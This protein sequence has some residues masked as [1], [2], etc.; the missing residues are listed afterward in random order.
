MQ[1]ESNQTQSADI[2]I[3]ASIR[4]YELPNLTQLLYDF[5]NKEQDVIQQCFRT[6]NYASLRDLPVQMMPNSIAKAMRDKQDMNLAFKPPEGKVVKLS[7]GGLFR[8]YEYISEP[9]DLYLQQKQLENKERKLKQ[10]DIS[11]KEFVA[12][13]DRYV[14][15]YHDCFLSEE[16]KKNYVLPYFVSDDPYE[17][18]DEELLHAK[19]TFEN[20]IMT[21]EFRPA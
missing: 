8:E 1:K 20:K 11:S 18:T 5:T 12:G 2:P 4:H 10:K 15:K 16:Q 14:W 13:S 3:D 19:W 7:G 9:F 21:G 17:A 6:G